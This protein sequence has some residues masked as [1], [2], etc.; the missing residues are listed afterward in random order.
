MLQKYK[1]EN[2]KL[3]IFWQIHSRPTLFQ[4]F[5]S[6]MSYYVCLF[7]QK[8]YTVKSSFVLQTDMNVNNINTFINSINYEN[9]LDAATYDL[10]N[11]KV[12]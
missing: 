1:S 10:L 8:E 9:C 3:L 2:E 11:L 12:T 5:F 7:Y 6:V 4:Y